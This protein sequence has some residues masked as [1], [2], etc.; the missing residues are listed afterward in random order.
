MHRFS[1][2][3]GY[4]NIKERQYWDTDVLSY[5]GPA[6]PRPSSWKEPRSEKQPV[7]YPAK[8]RNVGEACLFTTKVGFAEL[9]F[10]QND[11][12]KEAGLAAINIYQT[13][14]CLY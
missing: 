11:G 7:S 1:K 8:V 3:L 10:F 2:D 9:C 6:S 14:Q 12:G 5:F 4:D 13:T